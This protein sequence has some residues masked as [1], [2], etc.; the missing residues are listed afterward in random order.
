MSK[1]SKSGKKPP[2]TAASAQAL[3]H[4]PFG[5]L[6]A[7]DGQLPQ[8][9]GASTLDSE[10]AP[11]PAPPERFPK[12]LVVRMEKKGRRGKTVTRIAGLPQRD[13]NA[14]AVEMKKALGCG[15]MVEESE[16]VLQ[17]SLVERAAAWLSKQGAK[18]VVKGN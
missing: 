17:G 1:K 9:Q 13:L 7:L 15:A 4:N 18:Q 3:S 8:N 5:N 6:A 2:A 11:P 14:L 16:V 10:P 12:K